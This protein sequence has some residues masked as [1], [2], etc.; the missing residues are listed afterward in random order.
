MYTIVIS[1]TNIHI[2]LNL[3]FFN[4]VYP[5]VEVRYY[6]RY[7]KKRLYSTSQKRQD[8]DRE[9]RELHL[10]PLQCVTDGQCPA[11]IPLH[12]YMKQYLCRGAHQWHCRNYS[13]YTGRTFWHRALRESEAT[14]KK[15]I[16]CII[17]PI[18]HQCFG[19]GFNQV[20][21]SGL[22][23]RIRIQGGKNK[24]QKKKFRN[25]MFWSTGC[26]LLGAEGLSCS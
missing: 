3:I 24:P 5:S 20:S 18:F 21:G 16:R 10:R 25:V 7:L 17:L 26:S 12:R 6:F 23:I 2:Y 22:E 9:R 13:G 14:V 11:R 1:N 4:L 15:T 19:S 8:G